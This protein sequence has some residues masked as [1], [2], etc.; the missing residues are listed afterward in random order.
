M[1]FPS[2]QISPE[3]EKDALRRRPSRSLNSKSSTDRPTTHSEKVHSEG[4][5]SGQISS[6]F[7]SICR[8]FSASSAFP[9]TPPPTPTISSSCRSCSLSITPDRSLSTARKAATKSLR[10]L[11]CSSSWKSRIT[12]R[13]SWSDREG[14]AICPLST[15]TPTRL[16]AC[17]V[18]AFSCRALWSLL[19]TSEASVWLYRYRQVSSQWAW[20]TGS[21][22]EAAA[23][24]S[25]PSSV[26]VLNG[27]L[28]RKKDRNKSITVDR[29]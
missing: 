12:C 22:P 29:S 20:G 15:R 2:S 16:L 8:S 3:E 9:S 27:C 21:F 6:S 25:R 24:I 5:P 13:A 19:Q 18:F 28:A 10:N 26:S 7:L 4:P 1:S 11:R 17:W 14:T 23:E